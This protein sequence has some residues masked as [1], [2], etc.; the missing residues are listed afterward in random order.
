MNTREVDFLHFK[1]FRHFQ[2]PLWL[3]LELMSKSPHLQI[4]FSWRF[5]DSST[6]MRCMETRLIPDMEPNSLSISIAM[7]KAV[8][9]GQTY[10]AV[11]AQHSVTRT[12]VERR[13]KVLARTLNREVGIDGINEKGLGFADRLR[14]SRAA[15]LVALDRYTPNA[16]PKRPA[17]RTLN[18]EEIE[19]ALH[20]IRTRSPFPYRDMAMLYILLISGARPL[21]IARLEIRDYLN[22]D[23]SVRESSVMRAEVAVNGK[24]RPL[25]FSSRK[26]KEAIDR[27]LTE[28]LRRVPGTE[29]TT[30]YRGFDANDRLFLSD[31]GAEF[32]IVGCAESGQT[33]FLC[34]G[35][36]DAYRKIFRRTGL[37]GVS[38][39]NLRRTTAA[40]MLARGAI[41]EQIGEV[42]G[43]SELKAVRE[44]L[45]DLRQPLQSIVQ[46]L[47]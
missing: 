20:R 40:R 26:A 10:D 24:A 41:E 22:V 18:D 34:R 47:V 31:A 33:R 1:I 16:F 9:N 15:I 8:L 29:H 45:P 39:L 43:I 44:L 27:Y 14:Q 30:I 37:E 7:L 11:A 23:G 32:E 38:A 13:I 19:L 25:F 4:D 36:H 42:L 46:E 5:G 3:R 6:S 28:R 35:I 12:A 21:E 17:A 2:K